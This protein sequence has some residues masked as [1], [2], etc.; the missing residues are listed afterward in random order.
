MVCF[1][2][3]ALDDDDTCEEEDEGCDLLRYILDSIDEA[4][5]NRWREWKV[6]GHPGTTC[7]ERTDSSGGP[8]A[9]CGY[10]HENP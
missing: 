10:A 9:T 2:D 8:V 7:V 4:T 6:C 3:D 5:D 1:E